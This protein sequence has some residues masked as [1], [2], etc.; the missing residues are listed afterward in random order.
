[1]TQI[2]HTYSR[3]SLTSRAKS[4]TDMCTMVDAYE[5]ITSQIVKT[6][7]QRLPVTVIRQLN[8]TFREIANRTG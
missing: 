5:E 4:G 2:L 7:T 1:M 6:H 3:I 8:M